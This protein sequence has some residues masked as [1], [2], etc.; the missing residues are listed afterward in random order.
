MK[1]EEAVTEYATGN[2]VHDRHYHPFQLDKVVTRH[3][4]SLMVKRHSEG[5]A[6]DPYEVWGTAP[7]VQQLSLTRFRDEWLLDPIQLLS[8]LPLVL[9]NMDD[10]PGTLIS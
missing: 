7:W 6:M 8:W 9:D 5:K 3:D 10:R 4:D 1:A 2:I